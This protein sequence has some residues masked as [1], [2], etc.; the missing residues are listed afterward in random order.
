MLVR[1]TG[2]Y[3]TIMSQVVMYLRS[4][5]ED[6]DFLANSILMLSQSQKRPKKSG[7]AGQICD[8]I[9]ADLEQKGPK[10]GQTLKQSFRS[11]AKSWQHCTAY[12]PN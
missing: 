6:R 2:L 11:S 12:P 5:W 7:V 3:V 8:Q 4:S 9:L 10:R 1:A